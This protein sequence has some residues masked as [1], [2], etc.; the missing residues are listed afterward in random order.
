MNFQNQRDSNSTSI[1][2][3]TIFHISPSKLSL[4][5]TNNSC[6]TST[7]NNLPPPLM[8]TITPF[9]DMAPQSKGCAFYRGTLNSCTHCSVSLHLPQFSTISTFIDMKPAE[10]V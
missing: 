4:L 3:P 9:D 10:S 6:I 1:F 5:C 8:V 2:G 7:S